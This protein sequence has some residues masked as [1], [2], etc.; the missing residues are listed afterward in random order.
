MHPCKI[1]AGGDKCYISYEVMHY[2]NTLIR[3]QQVKGFPQ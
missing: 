3:G 1:N 2:K